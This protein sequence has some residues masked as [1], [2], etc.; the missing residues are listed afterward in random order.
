MIAGS[1]NLITTEGLRKFYQDFIGI[2][3]GELKKKME[4]KE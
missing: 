3:V 2:K 1:Q 4:S